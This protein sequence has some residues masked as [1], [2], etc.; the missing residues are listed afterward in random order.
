MPFLE[1]ES[2]GR[3]VDNGYP[4]RVRRFF[5]TSGFLFSLIS[6]LFTRL[7][8]YPPS[9]SVHLL[10]SPTLGVSPLSIVAF[11]FLP[12]LQLIVALISYHPLHMTISNRTFRPNTTSSHIPPRPP[13]RRITTFP[14]LFSPLI[15]PH[16]QP[17]NMGLSRGYMLYFSP[18]F[19]S[20]SIF[21]S[22]LET[23]CTFSLSLLT[24]LHQNRQFSPKT[25]PNQLNHSHHS[26]RL[27]LAL[28]SP[29]CV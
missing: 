19:H 21:F 12:F 14:C 3:L 13:S 5:F 15:L 8:L 29:S 22:F 9:L 18:H 27:S 11:A 10:R 16:N 4:Y 17:P 24:D 25:E 6:S 20:H 7:S 2:E 28:L 26:I 23:L 1:N